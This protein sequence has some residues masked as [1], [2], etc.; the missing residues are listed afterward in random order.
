MQTYL[1]IILGSDSFGAPQNLET[2]VIGTGKFSEIA[3][4]VRNFVAEHLSGYGL[5]TAR[6]GYAAAYQ[7]GTNQTYY[8]KENDLGSITHEEF[9]KRF[10][11]TKYDNED[12]Y[13]GLA[14]TYFKILEESFTK[15]VEYNVLIDN[16]QDENIFLALENTVR[17]FS[18]WGA[19]CYNLCQQVS[20]SSVKD[21]Y[22]SDVENLMS[23]SFCSHGDYNWLTLVMETKYFGLFGACF[24]LVRSQKNFEDHLHYLCEMLL[25]DNTGDEFLSY[26]QEFTDD[27]LGSLGCLFE[28]T[29]QKSCLNFNNGTDKFNL[30]FIAPQHKDV[31]NELFYLRE[32]ES[33]VLDEFGHVLN[34]IG[35]LSIH[36]WGNRVI[37]TI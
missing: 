21:D 28:K 11:R 2:Q 5:Y 9:H 15:A 19:Q 20:K 25:Y 12:I 3:L 14:Y 18:R 1:G 27:T 33:K 37:T 10:A 26:L 35:D 34:K 7:K 24:D 29:V 4:E 22:V 32:I 13:D 8:T 6:T 36:V 31:N 16:A 30:I 17:M 23:K